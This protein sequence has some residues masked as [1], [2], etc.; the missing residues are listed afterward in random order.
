MML[1]HSYFVLHTLTGKIV[2]WNPQNRSAQTL[3]LAASIRITGW[4]SVVATIWLALLASMC[5]AELA[6]M[7][8]VLLGLLAAPL[9]VWLVSCSK[10]G[11]RS[12]AAGLFLVP[13]ETQ[14]PPLLK[15][16]LDKAAA[17][18][19]EYQKSLEHEP[20][21]LVPPQRLQEM[22]KNPIFGRITVTR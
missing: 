22:P 10:L 19:H 1:Y 11:E 15:A 18:S 16:A 12:R 20:D 21:A 5:P 17:L 3:S 4:I 14:P 6:W 8:P 13:E 7:A 2:P 9:L